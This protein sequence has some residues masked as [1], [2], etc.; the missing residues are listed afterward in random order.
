[1]RSTIA[2]NNPV[3]KGTVARPVHDV[4]SFWSWF[5]KVILTDDLFDT[6]WATAATTD[7][8][9]TL[10]GYTVQG[11]SNIIFGGIVL[12][13]TRKQVVPCANPPGLVP[14]AFPTQCHA[15]TRTRTLTLTLTLTLTST[16]T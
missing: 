5:N 11:T 2:F 7:P 16:L 8:R 13:H 3:K 15:G 9:S 6:R 14:A 10:S 12:S 4:A 1:M